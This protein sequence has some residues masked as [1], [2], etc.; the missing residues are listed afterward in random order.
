[1]RDLSIFKCCWKGSVRERKFEDKMRKREGIMM[2]A[3]PGK[4]RVYEIWMEGLVCSDRKEGR[5]YGCKS[6]WGIELEEKG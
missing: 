3:G 1:M 4:I 5:E 6:R 2:E